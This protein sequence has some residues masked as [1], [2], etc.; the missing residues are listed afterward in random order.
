MKQI[1]IVLVLLITLLLSGC[2]TINFNQKLYRDGTFDLSIEVKS[3]NQMFVNMVKEGL[4]NSSFAEKATLIEQESG[5]KY[6][7]KRIPFANFY[8]VSAEDKENIF[9][10]IGIKKEFKFPY[11]FYT[12]TLKNK[13]L[14][15]PEYG[16]MG[17]SFNYIIEPFGTIT[18]TNGI[19]VGEDKKAV[20][21]NLMKSKEYYITFK[22]FL[23]FSW[24]GGSEIT[25]IEPKEL[26]FNSK[27]IPSNYEETDTNANRNF[28]SMKESDKA[29]IQNIKEDN[30]KEINL[31]RERYEEELVDLEA[32]K[33]SFFESSKQ[34][35]EDEKKRLREQL[36]EQFNSS[37]EKAHLEKKTALNSQQTQ[38]V[39]DVMNAIIPQGV[40]SYGGALGVSFEDPL[41][42]Q[43]KLAAL[44]RQIPTD[45]LTQ[46]E[47]QRYINVG[48]KI[49][50]EFCCSAPAVVDDQGQDL[51]GCAHAQ[52]FMGLSKYLIKNNPELIDDQ[53]LIELT[54]WKALYYPKNMVERGVIALQNNLPL[55]PAV[56]NDRDLLNK[57]ERK[58]LP[59]IA[60]LPSM[61]GGCKINRKWTYYI[62]FLSSLGL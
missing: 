34:N 28:N 59:S 48:T 19:Y 14:E 29:P 9:K 41:N 50:C 5:F 37:L 7:R 11:Y 20:K 54:K 39:Q 30:E 35:L 4:E 27:Q 15:D 10:S 23:I 52:A 43:N 49:S 12:I 24:F 3:D 21:F 31:L 36:L 16:S 44:H 40:P 45:S 13:G 22:D 46:N 42:S 47:L 57:V 1:T 62:S 56:L 55:T 8:N 26:S 25:N 60:Q 38:L 61:V 32:Q 51:C 58:D 18:D 33:R 53:I 17:L 2:G 6:T